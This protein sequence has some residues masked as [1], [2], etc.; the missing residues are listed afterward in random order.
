[1]ASYLCTACG[2]EFPP[3]EAPPERCPICQDERQ[4]VPAAG[5]S[6]VKLEAFA[7]AHSNAWRQYEPDVLAF[8]PVPAF[9]INQR[10]FLLRT[11][12]GNVLWDCV[13]LLDDAT[14]ALIRG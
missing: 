11:P 10:A 8:G 2:T 5:Q 9:A 6:W 3:A 1:M 12:H 13:S 4:Y 14:I 7:A